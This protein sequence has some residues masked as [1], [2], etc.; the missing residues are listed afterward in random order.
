M[1]T[2][3]LKMTFEGGVGNA[4][5]ISVTLTQLSSLVS[6]QQKCREVLT[7]DLT[8]FLTS[9]VN[10]VYNQ[11]LPRGTGCDVIGFYFPNLKPEARGRPE[12]L[13]FSLDWFFAF[14]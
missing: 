14:F 13:Q 4:L 9:H 12:R 1:T 7:F 11:K 3:G 8:M 10:E 5:N 2:L 6:C